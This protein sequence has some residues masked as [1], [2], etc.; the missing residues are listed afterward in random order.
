[1]NLKLSLISRWISTSLLFVSS[2]TSATT[3]S[4]KAVETLPPR[5]AQQS[6]NPQSEFT[7]KKY[8]SIEDWIE[9]TLRNETYRHKS[10]IQGLLKQKSKFRAMAETC[11]NVK[12]STNGKFAIRGTVF[13]PMKLSEEHYLI[14]LSC[15][16][17]PLG[18]N[19]RLFYYTTSHGID[20]T[21]LKLSVPDT[22]NFNRVVLNTTKELIGM[23][24]Y[25]EKK[26]ELLI[27]ITCNY[28]ARR[29]T[30]IAKHKFEHNKFTLKEF[31]SD[32][33]SNEKCINKHNL[34]QIY[35]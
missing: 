9:A 13:E 6:K 14:G 7:Q 8:E 1:M 29:L 20:I 21:P 16:G 32:A 22:D 27:K 10:V 18:H 26:K 17:Y 12:G 4:S 24:G 11:L 5:P 34:R 35:S 3:V 33:P 19:F 28:S 2:C 30:S 31:W 15:A 25:D 23:P